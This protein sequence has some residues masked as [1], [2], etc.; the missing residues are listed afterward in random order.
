MGGRKLTSENFVEPSI[1]IYLHAVGRE[2]MHRAL[3]QYPP[4]A[5]RS[6][7]DLRALTFTEKLHTCMPGARPKADSAQ[8]LI[9]TMAQQTGLDPTAMTFLAGEIIS[10]LGSY[11]AEWPR[12]LPKDNA[13]FEVVEQA[14]GDIVNKV[15]DKIWAYDR[16]VLQGAQDAILKTHF[17]PHP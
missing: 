12:P 11:P 4:H 10:D 5:V 7:L 8:I 13:A 2:L 1:S 15:I 3:V 14:A 17:P 6:G 9:H 16:S